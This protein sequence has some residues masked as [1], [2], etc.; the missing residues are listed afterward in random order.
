MGYWI[1]A[2]VD[3]LQGYDVPTYRLANGSVLKITGR[4]DATPTTDCIRHCP[5]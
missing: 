1:P 5:V 4:L 3:P 2:G